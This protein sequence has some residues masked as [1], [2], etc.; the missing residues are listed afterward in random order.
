MEIESLIKEK[1]PHMEK[2]DEEIE[3]WG[4][5]PNALFDPSS[6]LQ[7]FPVSDMS[8]EAKLNAIS[9]LV[10]LLTVVFYLIF[11]SYRSFFMGII[12]LGA[13]WALHYSQQKDANKKK[14]VRFQEGFETS[15][16]VKDFLEEHDIS[17]TLF[18][19]STP[20]NPLQNV[21]MTDYESAGNKRPAPAAYTEEAQ[22]KVLEHTKSMI[23]K[24]NP[25]QPKITNKL[26]RSLEDNLAF[27]QSMRPFYSTASTT[28]PNDQGAFADFCYGSMV[29]CKEGNPFAC[30]R[31]LAS[32]HT[33][34]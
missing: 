33:N 15:D 10:I 18:S 21:M 20:E 7:L 34:V 30:A 28:I 22:Q 23:D 8:Y 5:N 13:I 2:T 12:T 3:F 14:K 16:V 4:T 9:R 6:I 24:M 25:E 32:R 1:E 31:N 26:Y 11:R 19:E 29:S 27:E 17:E